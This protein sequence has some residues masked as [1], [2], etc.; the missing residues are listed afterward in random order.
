M[1]LLFVH[2]AVTSCLLLFSPRSTSWTLSGAVVNPEEVA[3]YHATFCGFFIG[4]AAVLGF[5]VFMV[6]SCAV[7]ASSIAR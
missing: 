2:F 5:I 3:W 7:A 4:Y 6:I 1:L